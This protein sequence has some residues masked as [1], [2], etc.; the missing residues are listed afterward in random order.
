MIPFPANELPREV[1]LIETVEWWLP[2]TR[3]QRKLLFN[4]LQSFGSGDGQW[5]WLYN[6]ANVL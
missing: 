2:R 5:R 1:R 3:G 4:S 6:L